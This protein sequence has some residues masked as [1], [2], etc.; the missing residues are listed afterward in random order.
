MTSLF[1]YLKTVLKI[2]LNVLLASKRNERRRRK[3][4]NGSDDF[5]FEIILIAE[6]IRQTNDRQKYTRIRHISCHK[7]I[8]KIILNRINSIIFLFLITKFS[9]WAAIPYNSIDLTWCQ[10]KEGSC[11]NRML[12]ETSPKSSNSCTCHTRR[13]SAQVQSK[14][15]CSHI[16][17][18]WIRI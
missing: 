11:A 10:S 8:K 1:T 4:T 18:N 5:S 9:L 6:R 15:K 3:K 7:I 16:R 17:F 12:L 14:F 2:Q 13:W